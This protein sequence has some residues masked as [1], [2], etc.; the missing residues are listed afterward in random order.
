MPNLISLISR[1]A[2]RAVALVAVLVPVGRALGQKATD[3]RDAVREAIAIQITAS[4]PLGSK[5]FS[6]DDIVLE[7]SAY[8]VPG[9][10]VFRA[11]IGVSHASYVMAGWDGRRVIP[12]GGFDQPDLFAVA[13]ALRTTMPEPGAIARQLVALGDPNGSEKVFLIREERELVESQVGPEWQSHVP[14]EWPRDTVVT[15]PSRGSL[16]VLTVLAQNTQ[17]VGQRW[18]PVTYRFAFDGA[19]RLISWKS[20][21]GAPFRG[22][23]SGA[24]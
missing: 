10:E 24:R 2:T 15:L 4:M 22:S 23:A 20:T 17:D 7:R 1:R 16:I 6:A 18:W 13:E 14:K 12:L 8:R 5:P 19:S 3:G 11:D 21:S 9:I